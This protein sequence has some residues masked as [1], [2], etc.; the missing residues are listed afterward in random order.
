MRGDVAALAGL[1]LGADA[2][3]LALKAEAA[4]KMA[5]QP[6]PQPKPKLWGQARQLVV[7]GNLAKVQAKQQAKQ[8][9]EEAFLS[10]LG[11]GQATV[12]LPLHKNQLSEEGGGSF[13][14]ALAGSDSPWRGF[15]LR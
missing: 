6:K 9:A 14:S 7:G 12:A 10:M 13:Q 3:A 4:G 2:Y 8:Q 11:A 5:A 1:G 15:D